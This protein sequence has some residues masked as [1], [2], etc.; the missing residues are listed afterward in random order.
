VRT[1]LIHFICGYGWS[2]AACSAVVNKVCF[3]DRCPQGSMTSGNTCSTPM[4]PCI[5]RRKRT[6]RSLLIP[7]VIDGYV[8]HA[9]NF[10]MTILRDA[11]YARSSYHANQGIDQRTGRS[12]RAAPPPT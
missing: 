4:H 8:G 6:R 11:T 7:R 5:S 10:V 12:A 3:P 2:V 1:V 9:P